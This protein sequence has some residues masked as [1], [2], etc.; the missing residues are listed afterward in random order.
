MTEE[1][2]GRLFQAFEQ[3]DSSTTRKYGGTGLGLAISKQLVGLM[4]GEI[5]VTSEPD[6][7]S[8]FRFTAR[9]GRTIAAPRPSLS[10]EANLRD[11]RVLIIDDNPPARSVLSNMLGS[12]SLT[13]DEA[14]SGEEG[15]KMVNRAVKGG[16]PYD[17]VFIDWQMP[18]LDGIETGNRILALPSLIA[19]PYLV[20]VTAYGRE[21]VLRM[22]ENSGFGS[23][24]IKPVTSSTLFETVVASFGGSIKTFGGERPAVPDLDVTRLRG[25]RVLLV[26]DNEINREVALGHLADAELIVDV[27][28]NGA[29]A[30]QMVQQNDYDG[31]LMDVQMPVMDGLEATRTIRSDPDL[32]NLPIIAMTASALA[33]DREAC[34]QA[35][36]NDHVAK[37]VEP[38]QLFGALNRWV[39]RPEGAGNGSAKAQ[40]RSAEDISDRALPEIAGIDTRVGLKRTGGN[41]K[42]YERLLRRFAQQQAD[43]ITGIS[44]ALLSGD[45]VTAERTAH[46]LKGAAGTLGAVALAE[47]AAKVETAL[48]SGQEPQA[49]IAALSDSVTSVVDAIEGALPDESATVDTSSDPGNDYAAVGALLGRL[50]QLLESDDGEAA[51]FIVDV[52]PSLSGI[53]TAAE[54]QTLRAL[55]EDFDFDASLNCLALIADRLGLTLQSS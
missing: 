26:E 16:K 44:K 17:V 10:L 12:M 30:V 39:K 23:I 51:D 42:R 48:K 13:A 28:E 3:A 41:S 52:E 46:S 4:G 43:V 24:L 45:S 18:G 32:Q 9:F 49:L 21:E 37:P 29:V 34:Q 8:T 2:I 19:Q 38:D 27:A 14:T 36:M 7:G 33:S 6:N 40:R 5:G 53:L 22:A 15:I 54:V 55:V 20:M 31:V 11:R 50:K 25:A 35:G 1:Q 47:L